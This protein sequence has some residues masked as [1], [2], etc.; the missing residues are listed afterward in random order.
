MWV[1]K[2]SPPPFFLAPPH[3][4]WRD[5]GLILDGLKV[6]F[7]WI[8]DK[9]RRPHV[10]FIS[11]LLTLLAA[12]SFLSFGHQFPI[13]VAGRCLQGFSA[14]L[15]WTSGLTLLTNVFGKER[16]G[17]AVG[18]TQTTTSI[19]TTAAPLLGG[20]V[21]AQGGYS[22]VCAMSMATVGIS[23]VLALIMV[24]PDSRGRWED[25]GSSTRVGSAT[26]NGSPVPAEE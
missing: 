25:S 8:A 15:V 18:Y 24:E 19:E 26:G 13:L 10:L 17:E 5:F 7:G 9:L 23:L 21:Y 14:S 12:T 2:P 6:L 16:N 4:I 20:L 11:G 3:E 1:I 22:A